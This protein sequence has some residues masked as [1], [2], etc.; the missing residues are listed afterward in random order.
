LIDYVLVI[1]IIVI[2]WF[3]LTK[4]VGS[5]SC[6]GPAGVE[7]NGHCR[8]FTQSGNRGIWIAIE[9]VVGVGIFWVMQGLTG[10]TPGKALLG[11]KVVNAEG[12]PPGILRA[13]LR[14][15]LWI[16]DDFPYIVPCLAGFIVALNSQRNQ[17]VGDM[18]AGTFVIRSDAAM[19]PG[20]VG[21]GQFAPPTGPGTP[22]P[23]GV[24]APPPTGPP[25]QQSAGQAADWYPDPQGKARLRYWDG[26][27]WTDHTSN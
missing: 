3:A 20:Q 25:V 1:A 14:S 24:S 15:I 18:A 19:A 17:R 7:I 16:V 10:K 9:I 8:G 13:A 22:P 5:G 26:Q 12:R 6:S 27:S 23:P 11:I 4:N 21:A 2:S